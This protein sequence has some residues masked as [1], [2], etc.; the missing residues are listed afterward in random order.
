MTTQ[1]SKI[2]YGAGTVFELSS[3]MG[4]GDMS[5]E[6]HVNVSSCTHGK[7]ISH[8]KM[9]SYKHTAKLQRT[10]IGQWFSKKHR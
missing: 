1:V 9:S 8:K 6:K 10:N 7:T 3:S 2:T 4:G 5:A